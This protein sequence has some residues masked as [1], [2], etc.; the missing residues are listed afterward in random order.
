[1]N[2]IDTFE[3]PTLPPSENLYASLRSEGISDE[4]YEHATNVFS[5]HLNVNSF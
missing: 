2:D 3:Y 5:I 4:G 1:M